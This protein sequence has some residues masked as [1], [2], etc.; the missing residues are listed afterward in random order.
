MANPG[1]LLDP[2]AAARHRISVADSAAD[3]L[4]LAEL[5]EVLLDV[6]DRITVDDAVLVGQDPSGPVVSSVSVLRTAAEIVGAFGASQVADRNAAGLRALCHRE[7]DEP[8]E[9]CG[10]CPLRASAIA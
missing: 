5:R 7:C 2:P 4:V 9:L 6:A 1:A 8:A 3:L 10:E